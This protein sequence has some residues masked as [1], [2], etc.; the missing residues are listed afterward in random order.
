[1]IKEYKSTVK[2][3]DGCGDAD[4]DR[5]YAAGHLST[6]WPVIKGFDI[7]PF[8]ELKLRNKLY[9]RTSAAI[10]EELL[11]AIP[12]ITTNDKFA[13]VFTRLDS[14]NIKSEE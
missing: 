8:C 6:E 1:M 11:E 5:H 12:K 9:E 7:C 13:G 2:I 3:C 10:I 4:H 14:T